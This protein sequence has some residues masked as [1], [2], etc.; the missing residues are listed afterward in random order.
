M[1]SDIVI[2]DAT[3][4]DLAVRA[5][6]V[7]CSITEYD[8]AAFFLLFF[9]ELTL[10]ACVLG[11]AVVFIFL[12]GGAGAAAALLLGVAGAL[13]AEDS[14][15]FYNCLTPGHF[16]TGSPILSLPLADYSNASNINLRRR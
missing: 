6:L 8:L 3:P 10:Q 15:E 11:G 16:L 1:E 7:R 13:A 2:R 12:G 4:Q 9:Q 5:E 14:E